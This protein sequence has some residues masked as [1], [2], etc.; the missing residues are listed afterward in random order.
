MEQNLN[1]LLKKKNSSHAMTFI[2]GPI[3]LGKVK[4]TYRPSYV[5]NNTTIIL[6]EGYL[7]NWITYKGWYAIKNK[8][9]KP[10]ET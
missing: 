9:T 7:C 8:V 3:L 2:F 5:S 6:L 4:T 1:H 10:K